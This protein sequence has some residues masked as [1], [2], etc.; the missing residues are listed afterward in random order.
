MIRLGFFR[1]IFLAVAAVFPVGGLM[2]AV[3]PGMVVGQQLPK[4]G[5]QYCFSCHGAKKQKGDFDFEPF[6]A[7]P[8]VARDRKVWEKV[9]ELLESHEMPPK[10]K[11]QPKEVE[12]EAMVKWIDGQLSAGEAGK[13]NPGRV[14]LRRMNREEYKNTIRDLLGVDYEPSDFP[15]DETAFGFDTIADVLTIQPLLM[16]RYLAAGEEIVKRVLAGHKEEPPTVWHRG[17]LM[18]PSN[19]EWVRPVGGGVMA[20]YREGSAFKVV[21]L[22][23]DGDYTLRF[24][25]HGELAGP[26]APRLA[27]SIDGKEVSAFDVKNAGKP[28]S[29]DVKASLKRGPHKI[30]VAYL[31]NYHE[32]NH[33]DPKMRGDRNVFLAGFDVIGPIVEK[34]EP[35]ASFRRVFSKMPEQGAEGKVARELLGAFASKAFRRPVTAAEMERLGKLVDRALAGKSPFTEAVGVGVQ[36]IL[37]SPTFLFRWELDP[38]ALKPG[39]VRNLNDYEVASRLSYFLWSSMPDEQ[40]FALA[41]KG[42]LSKGDTLQRE[43][44]RMLGDWRARAF[45]RNF[46][47]Q[48]LQ[49]RGIDE[50]EIDPGKFPK[51]NG[52]LRDAMREES[53]MFFDAIVREDRSIYELLDTDFTFVNQKLAELYGLPAVQGE[54]LQRV[55]LPAGSPRGG[56]LGQGSVLLATS[57]PTRTSPVV[58]GKWVLE[59]ILGTPPPPPPANV[60]PLEE[61]NVDKDAPLRLRLEQHRANADCAVCHDKIDPVGFT[62]ENFDAIGAWRTLDGKS[63]IDASGRL[64][65]GVKVDGLAGLKKLVKGE[66]FARAFTQK[67]MT[68]AIGRGIE[69]QDKVAV[70]AVMRQV[71]AGGYKMSALIHAVVGSDPFL[72]RKRDVANR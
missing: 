12:R 49:I 53:W 55:T 25:A 63:R 27:V 43:V 19:L 66:K 4:F 22:R 67:M 47:S 35:T 34:V 57:M 1:S 11:P 5:E 32:E 54:K 72:K 39:D 42:E 14:T 51:F 20:F 21:E 18:D 68:Y 24:R 59:Q 23:A 58:R 64:P 50:I 9:A 15:Q 6:A 28:V 41:A 52:K 45:V 3:V 7:K 44:T 56:V 71:A 36:A 70:D 46:S 13:S 8:N 60:P 29:Y 61:T 31:N 62:L 48:W 30:A 17:E 69:R 40:L 26:E 65:G 37:C 16:E 2:G 10:G 33:P 38:D